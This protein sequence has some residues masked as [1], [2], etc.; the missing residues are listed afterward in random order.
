MSKDDPRCSSSEKLTG[1]RRSES[2]ITSDINKEQSKNTKW[3]L[4]VFK[5]YL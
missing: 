3:S 4:R 2:N 1:A 5:E